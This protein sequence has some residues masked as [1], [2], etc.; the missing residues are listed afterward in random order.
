[1]KENTELSLADELE[2]M[3]HCLA[4]ELSEPVW[5]DVSKKCADVA[6]AL[7]I[8]QAENERLRTQR[9]NLAALSERNLSLARL[10]ANQA[11]E[12]RSLQAKNDQLEG[13]AS[14]G[15]M[16]KADFLKAE[17]EIEQQKNAVEEIHMAW[18]EAMKRLAATEDFTDI[19]ID[20]LE[21]ADKELTKLRDRGHDQVRNDVIDKVRQVLD[22]L[23]ELSE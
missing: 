13:E 4:L 14:V 20:A 16:Y 18:A 2:Q 1:M 7:R 3:A 6:D 12:L 23:N 21:A 15:A 8:L 19:V 9:V 10:A 11:V 5:L 22:R 17:A